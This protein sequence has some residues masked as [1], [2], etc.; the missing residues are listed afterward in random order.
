MTSITVA[1]FNLFNKIGR[2][3][4]RQPLVVEQLTDLRPDVI[5]LQEVD[6]M[7]DQ[8]MSL[9]RL[10]NAPLTEPPGYRIYHMGRPGRNAHREALA[11]MSRLPVEAHE[12]LDYL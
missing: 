4:E 3:G 7:I 6:L 1:T 12:G 2:W 5:G 10:V 9:C 8:G 11:V